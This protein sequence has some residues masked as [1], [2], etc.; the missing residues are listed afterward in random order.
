MSN[1]VTEVQDF[2]EIGEEMCRYCDGQC[3]G[4]LLGWKIGINKLFSFV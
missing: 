3:A 4:Q 1:S 2:Q